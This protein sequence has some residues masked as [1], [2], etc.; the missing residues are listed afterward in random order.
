[1]TALRP[2]SPAHRPRQTRRLRG[3]ALI[4]ALL[5]MALAATLAT[6]LIARQ[7]SWL[8]QQQ[9]QRDRA[10]ARLLTLA[11]VDWAR[12]VL[13]D[14][15]RNNRY[16]HP[17]EPWATPVPAMPAEEGEIAGKIEDEQSRLNL[18]NLVRQGQASEVDL[19]IYL[20]LLQQL[21]LPGQLADSLLDWLDSNDEPGADG[22]ENAYYLALKPAYPCANRELA[23]LDELLRVRGY[24]PEII[25]RLRPY[26]TALPGY[27][28]LNINT[29]SALAISAVLH[30]LA[31][32]EIQQIIAERERIPFKDITDFHH[33][34][35]KLDT[36]A[37]SS[38]ERLDTRSQYF[39]VT[40]RARVGQADQGLVA[41]LQRNLG[42]PTTRWQKF[43]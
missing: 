19:Q 35:G 6:T 16:D 13:A 26:V 31:Y 11:A 17:G 29:A 42:W 38:T 28:P 40:I 15:G 33:R 14:D 37:H 2:A 41:L 24:T 36:A 22:A 4:M 21:Q 5:V 43:E 3:A 25:E 32:P 18:N 12:A 10:Q 1:M 20:T 30:D 23:D 34:M 8:R 39:T 7:D 9:T 27:N